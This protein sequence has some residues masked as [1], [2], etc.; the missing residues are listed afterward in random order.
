MPV[1]WHSEGYIEPLM[2]L[3]IEAGIKGLHAIEPLAGK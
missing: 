1:F 3:A 2:D